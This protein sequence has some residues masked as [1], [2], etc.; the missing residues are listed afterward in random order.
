[1]RSA[2]IRCVLSAFG[3]FI[4]CALLMNVS[5]AASAQAVPLAQHV[6]L[7]VEENTS[8]G[9]VYPSGMPWLSGEGKKYGYAN[10]YYSD[11]SGSLLDY[12]YLASGS[13]ESNYQC[14]GA[15]VCSLPSGS[16]NFYCNAND[17][18]SDSSCKS[19]TS[20]DPITDENIFHL[21]NNQP[22][23]W[24]VY[25]Q[26]YL[27]A[28]GTVNVP[29][30]TSAN[31]P[32]YTHYYAR[33]DAAVWYEEVLSNV[34]GSQGNMVDF[35]QFGIDVANGTLPRFAIIL[36]DGCWDIADQSRTVHLL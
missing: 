26:N 18:Y 21:M 29:D 12:L 3:Y 25:A 33:H 10:N 6:V 31:Q 15:P 9:D 28:G 11:V 34:F 17:C 22:V 30:Y 14:A 32:P 36:P 4:L 8:F 1:M 20:K 27:N 19:T 24:K 23:S 35:E 7:V 5:Q 13:C 2:R 16:H